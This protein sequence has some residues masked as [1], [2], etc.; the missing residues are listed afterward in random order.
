MEIEIDMGAASAPGAAAESGDGLLDLAKE[1]G[2]A[3]AEQDEEAS[4]TPS[5]EPHS[6]D[7]VFSAFRETV[8]REVEEQDFS[9][10]YDLGIAY[11]EMGLI[12]EAISEF[13]QS[14]RS[15]ERFLESCS[16]LA[17]LFREKG[18]LDQAEAWYRKGL[19]TE[20]YPEGH[21]VGLRYELAELCTELGRVQE[22]RDLYAQVFG[23]DA[24]YRQVRERLAA[25]DGGG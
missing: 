25:I 7:E 3:L 2:E 17:S 20:G 23:L 9:T 22:A 15:S 24:N 11:K 12:D 4:I 21:Y 1:L 8:A 13:Q 18:M 14:S 5:E 16:M 6:F 10:H 19:G